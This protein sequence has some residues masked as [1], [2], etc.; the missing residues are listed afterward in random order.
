MT[1]LNI[2]II[3]EDE[4]HSK[5]LLPKLKRK[6]ENIPVYQ[7]NVEVERN[8][9]IWSLLK[10][11]KDDFYI[12]DRCGRLTYYV[13]Y[14]ISF[15][16][17]PFAKA[18]ILSTYFDEPC[19]PCPIDEPITTPND[20]FNETLPYGNNSLIS[21]DISADFN[22]S[23]NVSEIDNVTT[24]LRPIKPKLSLGKEVFEELK[25]VL[26]KFRQRHDKFATTTR[27][28]P[29]ARNETTAPPIVHVHGHH[30]HNSNSHKA[31]GKNTTTGM[32]HEHHGHNRVN[33]NVNKTMP[34]HHGHHFHHKFNINSN[35]TNQQR[36]MRNGHGNHSRA[37]HHHGHVLAN[38]TKDIENEEMERNLTDLFDS[39][40]MSSTAKPEDY[41]S[42][43]FYKKYYPDFEKILNLA[44][45]NWL[46]KS[47]PSQPQQ[48][49]IVNATTVA[50]ISTTTYKMRTTTLT[51]AK[52]AHI[53]SLVENLKQAKH[54]HGSSRHLI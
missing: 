27:T 14:P 19:G 15:L 48:K 45:A 3:N 50:P 36:H 43:S 8:K 1:D 28:T 5:L 24:T 6:A 21:E 29:P 53:A 39:Y 44:L 54:R 2:F 31:D 52:K 33:Q 51:P 47:I 32:H 34:K 13:P 4:K 22:I 17:R 35:L 37:P 23:T 12:Y 11:G 20:T 41:R 9:T 25:D 26:N 49:E 30:K 16:Y 38:E 42:A 10:G 18:A 46:N 7:D 40:N